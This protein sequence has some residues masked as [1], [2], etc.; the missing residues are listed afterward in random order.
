[1]RTTTGNNYTI[2]YPNEFFETRGRF[3]YVKVEGDDNATANAEIEMDIKGD[4][5]GK[6]VT[7]TR[8]TDANKMVVFPIGAVCES[9][10]NGGDTYVSI[11]VYNG[12]AK[13]NT[14]MIQLQPIVGYWDREMV[15]K[16]QGGTEAKITSPFDKKI[17]FY[18]NAGFDQTIF[19]PSQQPCSI[20]Y[21]G[22]EIAS[23]LYGPYLTFS[24]SEVTNDNY[25]SLYI[26]T[27]S[28]LLWIPINAAYDPCTN[29]VFLKWKDAA[30]MP[31]L[32]RWT[33]EV[34]TDEVSVDSTYRKLDENLAPYDVQT[35]TLAKRYTLH[36]RIVER[37]IF[38]MCRT[39]LGAQEV[40]MYDRDIEDWVRVLIEDA[41][42]EDT[43]AP[44]QDVEIEVVK[45][46]YL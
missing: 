24:P 2:T 42:S 4:V 35:K 13:I 19:I 44:M 30:G 40:F 1:M 6:I 31:Y 18:P 25:K 21:L 3:A 29:G 39:I 16:L 33:Q 34:E 7:V 15:I 27:L 36:S 26:E 5:T 17:V 23:N 20:R 43:G 10:V 22:G 11:S 45:Y 8:T 46:E 12:G 28:P 41:E 14:L 38:E 37:D 32:Y 9:L